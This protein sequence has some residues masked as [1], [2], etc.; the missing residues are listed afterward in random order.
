[1]STLSDADNPDS[2]VKAFRYPFVALIWL[3]HFTT[4]FSL[5]TTQHAPQKASST[6]FV[7][8]G[9]EGFGCNIPTGRKMLNQA[10]H[11]VIYEYTVFRSR[12]GIRSNGEY[13]HNETIS[14]DNERC[15]ALFSIFPDRYPIELSGFCCLGSNKL[16]TSRNA[17][18]RYCTVSQRI[19]LA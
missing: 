15:P 9:A 2:R 14:A 8:S 10:F 12:V 18:E 7:G 4:I 11:T 13:L 1:M 5:Y 3:S 6:E 19:L 16:S 17:T